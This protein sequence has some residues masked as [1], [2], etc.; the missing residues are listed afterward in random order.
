MKVDARKL[1]AEIAEAWNSHDLDRILSHYSEDF[2]LVSPLVRVKMG[3][4]NGTINGRDNVRIWWRAGLDT[5]P[6]LQMEL[7]DVHEGVDSFLFVQ[8]MSFMKTA[9]ISHFWLN[10]E[11]LIKREEFFYPSHDNR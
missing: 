6:D 11:G 8:R 10:E 7:I 1:C 2:V 4:A 9:S 3:I 5:V